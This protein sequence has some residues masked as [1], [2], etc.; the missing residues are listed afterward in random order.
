MPL[1]AQMH[2]L[3]GFHARLL[4]HVL[5]F[6]AA[7]SQLEDGET[8]VIRLLPQSAYRII[9]TQANWDVVERMYLQTQSSNDFELYG[10]RQ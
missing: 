6:T 10:V 1:P 4:T 7:R 5:D 3:N 2:S 9:C 8:L